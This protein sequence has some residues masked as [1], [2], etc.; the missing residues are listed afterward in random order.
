MENLNNILKKYKYEPTTPPPQKG[1]KKEPVKEPFIPFPR[2][3]TE[4]LRNHLIT[5][6][7]LEL[8]VWMRL[9][10][11]MYG[12]AAIS[13]HAMLGDLPHFKSVDYIT[14][15]L[16]SLLKKKYVYYQDR[17]GHRGSF[18]VHFGD[19]LLKGGKVKQLDRFFDGG[20]V[21]GEDIPEMKGLT[22]VAPTLS[23]ESRRWSSQET[24]G[25]ADEN[26]F[27]DTHSVRGDK[28]DNEIEKE[29]KKYDIS[30]SSKEEKTLKKVRTSDFVPNTTAERRC[31]E[32]AM[33][34]GDPYINFAMSV[35]KNNEYGGLD[36]LEDG[37]SEYR[38]AKQGYEAKGKRIGNP[39]ALFNSFIKKA[40]ENKKHAKRF[41]KYDGI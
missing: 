29:K 38:K 35:L 3:L 19:W 7:E 10:A 26:S 18:N 33:E 15:I 14:K 5:Y 6:R 30:S 17:K 32:T 21:R 27:I 39:A 1:S 22:E 9:H 31:K 25:N 28:N 24:K 4:H 40:M 34:V 16:R 36:V 8:Y 13:T 37:L 12:I 23:E 11:N 2:Y 41:S 20:N